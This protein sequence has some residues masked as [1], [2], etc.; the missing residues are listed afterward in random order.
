MKFQFVIFLLK[1]IFSCVKVLR[2][3]II[4]HNTKL[5]LLLNFREISILQNKDILNRFF[6]MNLLT[7][8]GKIAQN[9][10]ENLGTRRYV[11]IKS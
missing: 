2:I 7:R 8:T 11:L 1:Y 6:S 9:L 10:P 4:S 3:V 5:I